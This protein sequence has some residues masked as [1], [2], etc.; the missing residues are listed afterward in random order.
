MARLTNGPIKRYRPACVSLEGG[1]TMARLTKGSI[2]RYRP[3]CVSLEGGK[4]MARLTKG[5]IKRHRLACVL[6][7]ENRGCPK[8][9]NIRE[10]RGQKK[11]AVSPARDSTRRY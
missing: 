3:A 2:K 6:L 9:S 11:I 7:E 8:N 1:K 4:T 10:N 5:S